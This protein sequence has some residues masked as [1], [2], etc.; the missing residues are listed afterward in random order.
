[1][2]TIKFLWD[3]L[4]LLATTA[5]LV[6]LPTAMLHPRARLWAADRGSEQD[7]RSLAPFLLL[8]CFLTPLYSEP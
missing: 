4:V 5:V 6:A 3:V 2:A 7:S 8:Y 1:M